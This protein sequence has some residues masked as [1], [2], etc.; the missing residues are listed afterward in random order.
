MRKLWTAILSFALLISC[1]G[2]TNNTSSD[3]VYKV[4]K[5]LC[6]YKSDLVAD[7]IYINGDPDVYNYNSFADRVLSIDPVNNKIDRQPVMKKIKHKEYTVEMV[8]EVA[9]YKTMLVYFNKGK[10]K[11]QR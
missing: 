11:Y 2:N 3:G 8:R 6:R 9:K 1:G 7:Y 4:E 5:E 10:V